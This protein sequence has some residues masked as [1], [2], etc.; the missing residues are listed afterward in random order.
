MQNE[1]YVPYQNISNCRHTR[2]RMQEN[3]Y[4]VRIKSLWKFAKQVQ[5]N[6]NVINTEALRIPRNTFPLELSSANQTI[7]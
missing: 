2:Y 1:T 6:S 4:K 3:M 7:K 5:F